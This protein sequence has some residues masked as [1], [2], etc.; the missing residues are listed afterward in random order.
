MEFVFESSPW[1]QFAEE[2]KQGDTVSASYLL[3][4][5]E[6]EDEESVEQA[7]AA[8]EERAV[9][10]DLA[11]LPRPAITGESGARLRL[12]A[13]LVRQDCFWLKLEET[14]PLRLY[15]EELETAADDLGASLYRVVQIAKGFTGWGVLLSDLI[16]EGS[17]GLWKAEEDAEYRIRF[18]MQKA[19]LLYARAAGVGQKLS[20]SLEDYRTVDERLLTELGRNP[21]LEEIAQQL[22][23]SVEE[24]AFLADMLENIRLMN[25]VK[26][27]QK[28]EKEEEE[29]Q[30]VENTAYFQMR[31][32]ITEMLSTL[33]VEDAQLLT[34]RFG[35]DS[36]L[37]LTPEQTGKKLGLTPDEVVQKE[38]AALLKLRNEG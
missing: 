29:G 24:A 19:V 1:E 28:P 32:R 10:I 17:L 4:V 14:D 8:L 20:Q 34:L 30:A 23:V 22:H 6:G 9:Q 16:Q 18:Y 21:T 2:L 38:A 7:L 31:Q 26:A 15:M 5:L 35:L 13:E 11:D 12:E 33:P 25:R 37:P 36:G 3:T 27:P